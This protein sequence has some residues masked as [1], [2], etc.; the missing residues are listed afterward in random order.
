MVLIKGKHI[1]YLEKK[2]QWFPIFSTKTNTINVLYQK[3]RTPLLTLPQIM[4]QE[5]DW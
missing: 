4:I 5:F 1:F 3:I 2:F